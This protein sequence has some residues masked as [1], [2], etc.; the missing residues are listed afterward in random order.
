MTCMLCDYT[1][2]LKTNWRLYLTVGEIKD[3][4]IKIY[5]STMP[6]AYDID[7]LYALAMSIMPNEISKNIYDRINKIIK[8][9]DN[10]PLNKYYKI[11]CQ[12]YIMKYEYDRER[13]HDDN[14]EIKEEY[15]YDMKNI[16]KNL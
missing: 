2:E 11:V 7:D 14:Y 12:E 16:H 15:E 8:I 5:N 1:N 9:D 3:L 6:Y 13:A 4:M 10:I